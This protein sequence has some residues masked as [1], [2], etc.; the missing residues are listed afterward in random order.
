[1][2]INLWGMQHD[3]KYWQ[4]A[5]AFKPE[6]WIGDKTGGDRSG[7]LA[8]M[9]FGVGPRM[10]IGIK[11][12]C[13]PVASSTASVSCYCLVCPALNEMYGGLPRL[14]SYAMLMLPCIAAKI[15]CHG[16]AES[17]LLECCCSC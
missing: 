9:P 11:L 4:D 10:C 2:H 14:P 13:K 5:E 7:G 17:G 3:E 12:A 6:R 15:S 8:Y 1:M 16:Y